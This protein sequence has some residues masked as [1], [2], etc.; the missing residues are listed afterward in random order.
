MLSETCCA[1]SRLPLSPAVSGLCLPLS[2]A[3]SGLCLRGG[4]IYD[5]T[6]EMTRAARIGRYL[7]R[8]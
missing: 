5:L 3:V 1:L 7:S 2:P 4:K 8:H 6:S